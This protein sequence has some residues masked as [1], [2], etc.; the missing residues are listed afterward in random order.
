MPKERKEPKRIA[1]ARKRGDWWHLDKKID[2][3]RYREPLNTKD[4][5]QVSDLISHRIA[6]IKAGKV[7]SPA[8]KAF[9]RL[10]LSE[11]VEI[12]KTERLGKVSDRTTQ[13]D[14]ERSVPLARYFKDR[15][16]R[17]F[18]PEDISA[19][20]QSRIAELATRT[21]RT[22]PEAIEHGSGRTVNMETGIL[23]QLLEKAK[24]FNVLAEYPKPFPEQVR[25]I[26]KAL[27]PDVKLHLFRVASGRPD[28]LVAYCAAAAAANTTCRGVELKNLQWKHVNLFDA[29][30]LIWRTKGKTAGRREIPLNTDA[31]AA[32]ARLRERA[33][34]VGGTDPEHFVF[35]ACEHRRIDPT[36][37]QKTWRTAWRAL[38]Q[39]AARQ[40]GREAAGAALANVKSIRRAVTAWKR[41]A[42]PYAGF[43][44][45]DLR[46]QAVTEMAEAGA[47]DSVIQALAGHMSK[48]MM[49]HY[50]HVRRAAKR[51]VTDSLPGGLMNLAPAPKTDTRP[52]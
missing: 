49:D 15:P 29:I 21:R 24:L 41:A 17:T 32:F 52:N 9:A 19:Y 38:R 33:E 30:L 34:I 28:W 8:G 37:P 22:V 42:A 46:H 48:R 4:W 18:K 20:Q 6:E 1:G 44:F 3:I 31:L 12:F 23:R 35:P 26:G 25:E 36:K 10:T 43:R 7:A 11:A 39:E 45:H 5:R 51:E 13:L 2:G 16:L 27:D 47:P 40:A 50:S 14:R